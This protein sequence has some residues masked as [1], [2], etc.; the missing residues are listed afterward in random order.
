[1]ETNKVTVNRETEMDIYPLL[2]IKDM[3]SSL[4]GGTVFT[5]L[6]LAHAYQQVEELKAVT[7]INT[8][9]GLYQSNRPPFG[10]ASAPSMFQRIMDNVVQGLPAVCAYINNILV[11]GK[12]VD[13]H[14]QN[15]EAI[16][17]RLQESGLRLKREKCAFPL[18][19]I[20]DFEFQPRDY[21]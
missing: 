17:T 10:V 12:K 2:R 20:W 6:D 4:A 1:M 9:K 19:R 11:S 21:N 7:T 14:L 3:F 5:K 8:H 13:E 15:L 18:S 16:L